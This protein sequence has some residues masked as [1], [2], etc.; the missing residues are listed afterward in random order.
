MK[1]QE[2]RPN[3]V[4]KNEKLSKIW[5]YLA[6]E[7]EKGRKNYEIARKATQQGR[8]KWKIIKNMTPLTPV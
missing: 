2:K 1:L 8:T 6:L 4:V 7:Q 5:P 3:R